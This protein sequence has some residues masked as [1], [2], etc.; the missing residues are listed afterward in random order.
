LIDR[1]DCLL[2][3]TAE[4]PEFVDARHGRYSDR[5]VNPAY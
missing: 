2:Q 4:V 3:L 1:V 5:K